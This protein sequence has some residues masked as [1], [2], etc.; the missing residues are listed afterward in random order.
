[1]VNFSKINK[2]QIYIACLLIIIFMLTANVLN[3]YNG[4]NRFRDIGYL[5]IFDL[6]SCYSTWRYIMGMEIAQFVILLT[7][8]LIVMPA[9]NNFY[10]EYRSGLFQHKL[11]MMRYRDYIKNNIISSWLRTSFWLPLIS[12]L[13]FLIS[14]IAFPNYEVTDNPSYFVNFSGALL[15]NPFG[16]FIMATIN[17]FLFS[18][19]AINIGYIIARY[20]K[21]FSLVMLSSFLTFTAVGV[22]SEVLIGSIFV[23]Q[24]K[25]RDII[26]SFSVYNSWILSNVPNIWLNTVYL[27]ILILLSL[28]IIVKI[29]YNKEKVI[30]NHD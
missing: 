25:M 2:H 16:G 18:V 24:T 12:V 21:N 30:L 22:I 19:L 20:I 28:F 29:Y 10:H 9:I 15:K 5:E 3:Y 17:M 11:L 8:I 27:L 7:P 13:V 1:M 14:W 6:I 4:L 23:W 26:N